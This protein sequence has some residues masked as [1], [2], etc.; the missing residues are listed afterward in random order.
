MS[1]PALSAP[2]AAEV[3]LGLGANVGDPPAQLA[4]AVNALRGFVDDLEASSLYR[5]EPVGFRAQPD[6]HNL[7]VRGRTA[8]PPE[9]LLER[10]L[11][12]E[13]T[14]GRERTFR[15]APRVI[16]IDVLAYGDEVIDLPFLTLPHPGIPTRG[17]VLHPLAEVAPDWRHPVL[18]R[19]AREL[20]DEASA[21]ERVERVGPLPGSG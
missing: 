13:R 4:A 14:L 20:L 21:L 11:E 17:F 5:T 6:F 12:V 8:L 3:L 16:D 1:D 15:N 7:V 10:V 9:A 2:A 19:T 18:G